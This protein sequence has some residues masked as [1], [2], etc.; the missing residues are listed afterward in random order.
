MLK[1]Q[2]GH[3]VISVEEDWKIIKSEYQ[4]TMGYYLIDSFDNLT[5]LVA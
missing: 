1:L 3:F 4:D 2:I 5:A